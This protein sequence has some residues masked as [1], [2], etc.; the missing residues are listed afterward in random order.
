MAANPDDAVTRV[1]VETGYEVR[2]DEWELNDVVKRVI[3][4]YKRKPESWEAFFDPA[5][6]KFIIKM[7][8]LGKK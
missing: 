6:K 4:G 5:K 2:Y 3:E 1:D 8:F 7:L